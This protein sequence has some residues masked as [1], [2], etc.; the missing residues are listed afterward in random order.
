MDD[1]SWPSFWLTFAGFAVTLYQLR[2]TRKIAEATKDTVVAATGRVRYNQLLVLIPQL[3]SLESELDSALR[4]IDPRVAER[5]LV[6]WKQLAS[7]TAGILGATG[8]AQAALVSELKKSCGLAVEAKGRLVESP[9]DV[10]TITKGVREAISRLC[11]S[12]GTVLGSMATD[13]GETL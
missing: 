9:E 2:R 8:P 6:R 4:E 12:L 7:Q 13:A 3:Q 10:K 1:P 5:A 11:D